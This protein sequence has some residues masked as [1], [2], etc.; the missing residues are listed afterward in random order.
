MQL[1]RQEGLE[2]LV[3]EASLFVSSFRLG[4]VESVDEIVAIIVLFALVA[5]VVGG[6]LVVARDEEAERH[7]HV[8]KGRLRLQR[9]DGHGQVEGDRNARVGR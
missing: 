6:Q 9:V 1:P 5:A 2:V 3:D 7:A 8:V 4:G